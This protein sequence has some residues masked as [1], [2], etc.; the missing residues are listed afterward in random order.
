MALIYECDRCGARSTDRMPRVAIAVT[1]GGGEFNLPQD[2]L[3]KAPLLCKACAQA[4][5]ERLTE[6]LPRSA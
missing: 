5:V 3:T 4:V 6:Q 2:L 1:N